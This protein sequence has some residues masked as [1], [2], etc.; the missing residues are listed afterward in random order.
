MM[1][2]SKYWAVKKQHTQR[3]SV[4]KMRVL[5]WMSGV[6]KKDQ[7]KDEF[8]QNRIGVAPISDNLKENRL[9]YY[10]HVL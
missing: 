8:I 4:T 5:R 3:T 6:T 7:L 10:G 1:Y 9:R 2:R